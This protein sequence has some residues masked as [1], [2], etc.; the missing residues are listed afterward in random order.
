MTSRRILEFWESNRSVEFRR[1]LL[2]DTPPRLDSPL[3]I[4]RV[5]EKGDYCLDGG[6]VEE[7]HQW[8]Y[9]ILTSRAT[10]PRLDVPDAEIRCGFRW[11]SVLKSRNQECCLN[12]GHEMVDRVLHVSSD[13]DW[14]EEAPF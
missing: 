2:T 10:D 14:F 5:G 9:E 8:T 13:G 7:L 3:L 6:D 4:I 12:D 1:R 11:R